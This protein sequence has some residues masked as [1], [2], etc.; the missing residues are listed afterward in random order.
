MH[1]L[2]KSQKEVFDPKRGDKNVTATLSMILFEDSP[3]YFFLKKPSFLW[4]N[5][6]EKQFLKYWRGSR[7]YTSTIH[8]EPDIFLIEIVHIS[9]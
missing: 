1:A 7:F 8:I 9:L 5:A 4:I 6:G 2:Q 3:F